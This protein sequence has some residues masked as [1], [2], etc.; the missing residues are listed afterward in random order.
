[1]VVTMIVNRYVYKGEEHEGDCEGECTGDCKVAGSNL[2]VRYVVVGRS[3]TSA[4]CGGR[5]GFTPIPK[6]VLAARNL[7]APIRLQYPR[8]VTCLRLR[9]AHYRPPEL[10]VAY[11]WPKKPCKN[12]VGWRIACPP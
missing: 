11:A 8:A 3:P 4:A 5:S 12:F 9:E 10:P 7:A 6:L 1:M 2:I